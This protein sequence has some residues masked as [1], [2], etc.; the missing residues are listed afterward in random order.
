[1]ADGI[2]GDARF[3]FRKSVDKYLICR[4]C[5]IAVQGSR[6]ALWLKSCAFWLLCSL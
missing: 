6:G 5:R 1:M 2:R 3:R 4:R